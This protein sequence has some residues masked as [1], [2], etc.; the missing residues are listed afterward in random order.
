MIK[1]ICCKKCHGVESLSI[2]GK[3]VDKRFWIVVLLKYGISSN[4][5]YCDCGGLNHVG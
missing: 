4:I 1:E 2:D 5:I 3:K